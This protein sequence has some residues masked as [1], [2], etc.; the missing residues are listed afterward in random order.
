VSFQKGG[1]NIKVSLYFTDFHRSTPAARF[2][3]ILHRGS[4]RQRDQLL[5]ILEASVEGVNSVGS[6]FAIAH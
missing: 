6:K 5:Q 2:T 4:S 3:P 1:I